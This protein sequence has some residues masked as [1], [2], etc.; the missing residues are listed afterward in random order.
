[1]FIRKC[2]YIFSRFRDNFFISNKF[3]F[4]NNLKII[5]KMIAYKFES[6]VLPKTL[7]YKFLSQI[8]SQCD[9]CYLLNFPL[10]TSSTF[11]VVKIREE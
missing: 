2:N 5:S 7:N 9:P 6:C 4:L 10:F 8:N 11:H 1:M 3:Q